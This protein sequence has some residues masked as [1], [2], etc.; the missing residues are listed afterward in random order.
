MGVATRTGR[1]RAC[2]GLRHR[3]YGSVCKNGGWAGAGDMDGQLRSAPQW[4]AGS[5]NFEA[6]VIDPIDRDVDVKKPYV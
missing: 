3:G 6:A 2:A 4:E 1:W 5:D